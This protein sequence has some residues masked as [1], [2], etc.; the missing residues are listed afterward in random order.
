MPQEW[1]AAHDA[2]SSTSM[3]RDPSKLALLKRKM[4]K[5]EAP[6]RPPPPVP[7]RRSSSDLSA[8]V[9][10]LESVSASETPF[11]LAKPPPPLPRRRSESTRNDAPASRLPTQRV[12]PAP[13]SAADADAPGPSDVIAIPEK[14]PKDDVIAETCTEDAA[15]ECISTPPPIAAASTA[16]ARAESAPLDD[17]PI[18]TASDPFAR[19]SF[20]KLVVKWSCT[21]C[22]REC[23]PVR[24]ESRCLC[25][26]RLKEHP[27]SVDDPRVK[28]PAKFKAFACTTSRCVCKAF[29]YIVAEGAW[30]LRC[31]CKHKHVEHDAGRPPFVCKKPKCACTGFDSPWVCN[32]AHPWSDHVQTQEI[33]TFHPLQM[34]LCDELSKVYRTDLEAEPLSLHA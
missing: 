30:I 24:E 2:A 13:P 7:P 8:P 28:D 14:R 31:R 3:T 4:A 11:A 16:T 23:I 15:D 32:C 9:P 12:L 6:T 29:F 19:K 25:D 18:S 21:T 10:S 34:D 20:Q 1:Y 5:K 22:N 27:S 26:H 33:K 17:V